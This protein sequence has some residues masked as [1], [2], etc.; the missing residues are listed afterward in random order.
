MNTARL[1]KIL[2]RFPDQRIL[3]V[4]DVMLDQFIWGRVSRISPEAPVPVVEVTNESCYPGGAANVARNLR[5]LGSHV[6]VLGVIGHDYSGNQLRALL[7]EQGIET[8]T[9]LTDETR[10][11]TLKTRVIAHH[12]QVVRFDREHV[13][14]LSPDLTDRILELFNASLNDVS[15]VIFEDYAKGLLNQT[16]LEK[17]QRLADRQG[18]IT[19]ADPN[20]RHPLKFTGLTAITPNRSEAFA[21]AD[22]P[23]AQP[24]DDVLRD[25]SLLRVGEILL[26]RWKPKNLLITLGEHGM[27]LFRA[28]QKPHHIPTVAQEVFDVSG[29]GDT[30]IAT[31]VLALA[32]GANPVEAAALSNHASGIV[33][34]KV[35]TATCSTDELRDNFRRIRK[36]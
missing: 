23:Y 10:P 19:A 16:L 11:T 22:I 29:A 5:A 36:G 15:A 35:G 24:I 7:D 30:A 6:R 4:G 31:L 3:V 2:K 12:Q 18:K 8:T 13:T 17:M 26:K 27:C 14:P 28:G 20:A 25:T 33:V 21:A 9:L 32:A 1:Q 34:G